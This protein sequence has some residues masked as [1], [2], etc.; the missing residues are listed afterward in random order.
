MMQF[1]ENGKFIPRWYFSI[2][3]RACC[4][5]VGIRFQHLNRRFFGA[6]FLGLFYLSLSEFQVALGV[7]LKTIFSVP[8]RGPRDFFL[9]YFFK[10]IFFWSCW[11]RCSKFSPIWNLFSWYA[12]GAAQISSWFRIYLLVHRRRCTNFPQLR[13]YFLDTP[14]V[15]LKISPNFDHIVS[16]SQRLLQ[17]FS[18]WWH[19]FLFPWRRCQSFCL[20][21]ETFISFRWRRC[22]IFSPT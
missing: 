18:S 6:T 2:D 7:F 8:A 14:E 22:Q 16:E 13:T 12:G 19:I 4:V 15:L 20:I 17:F 10:T 1:L 21:W 3:P 11:R 5:R 9:G